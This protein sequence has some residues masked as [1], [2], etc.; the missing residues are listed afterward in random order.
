M[1]WAKYLSFVPATVFFPTVLTL[2]FLN[3]RQRRL[4]RRLRRNRIAAIDQS[5]ADRTIASATA[6]S[7][8]PEP[9]SGRYA[10][11][12]AA[13]LADLRGEPAPGDGDRSAYPKTQGSRMNVSSG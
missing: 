12:L 4:R 9:A 2:M 1:W 5:T 7:G 6:Q 10:A 11:E 3:W 13:A 8:A